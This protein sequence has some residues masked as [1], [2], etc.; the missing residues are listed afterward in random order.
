LFSQLDLIG[1]GFFAMGIYALSF[2]MGYQ[3]QKPFSVRELLARVA[4]P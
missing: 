3:G 1:K 2:F 4:A